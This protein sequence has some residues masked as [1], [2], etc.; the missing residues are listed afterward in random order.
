MW[1]DCLVCSFPAL[2]PLIPR[3]LQGGLWR[4]LVAETVN[5]SQPGRQH[6]RTLTH[7]S[8]CCF[9]EP[10]PSGHP[11]L[12]EEYEGERESYTVIQ[13]EGRSRERER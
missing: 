5:T 9:H 13:A 1:P 6:E 11:N 7:R 12:L 4:H 2:A 8:Q 3:G 10:W